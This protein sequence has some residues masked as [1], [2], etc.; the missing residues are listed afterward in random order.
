MLHDLLVHLDDLL[1]VHA[2]DLLALQLKRSR[3]QSHVRCPNLLDQCD[4]GWDFESCQF[5]FLTVLHDLGQG[6]LDNLG[7][8]DE[9]LQIRRVYS[10]L[11]GDP[12]QMHW[13]RHNQSHGESLCRISV[14]THVFHN[15]TRLHLG[16]HFTQRHILAGLQFYQVLFAI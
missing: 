7:V 5:A 15:G 1:L 4:P 8:I 3:H 10:F 9:N 12:L 11:L 2:L 13:V 16:L 6:I 14:D